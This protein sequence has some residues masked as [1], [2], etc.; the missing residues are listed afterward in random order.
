MFSLP[1]DPTGVRETR[2]LA[3]SL[4]ALDPS[5]KARQPGLFVSLAVL[6]GRANLAARLTREPQVASAWGIPA[7]LGQATAPL[8]VFSALGGPRDSIVELGAR[9]RRLVASLPDA[10]TRDEVVARFLVRSATLAGSEDGLLILDS[11]AATNDYLWSMQ[12]AF[13]RNEWAAVRDSMARLRVMR[14]SLAMEDLAFDA[15]YPE[16]LLLAG[17]GDT[18]RTPPQAS[19]EPSVIGSLVRAMV[20]RAQIAARLG[21]RATAARWAT[22]VELLWS[23]ADSFLAAIVDSMRALTRVTDRT[24]H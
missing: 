1:N 2:L 16:A 22:S 18:A 3:D 12:Q 15:V 9:V 10:A 17:I 20:L 21:D 23:G 8:L 24:P 11:A 13:R 19:P 5:I 7:A 14:K 4:L 6:L